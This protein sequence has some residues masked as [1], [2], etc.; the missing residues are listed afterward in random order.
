[1]V[2]WEKLVA[3]YALVCRKNGFT[4]TAF[5]L[6]EADLSLS[7]AL[8]I[9][10]EMSTFLNGFEYAAERSDSELPRPKGQGF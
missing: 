2:K 10:N 8:N 6:S 9:I 7:D 3:E 1:M 4:G 5:R